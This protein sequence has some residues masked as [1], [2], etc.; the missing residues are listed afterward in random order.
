MHYNDIQVAEFQTQ[1]DL[2]SIEHRYDNVNPSYGQSQFK[3][4]DTG[5]Q[6][7]NDQDLSE[8]FNLVS[9]I[10]LIGINMFQ[11]VFERYNQYCMDNYRT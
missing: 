1:Q 7:Y 5:Q 8:L 3:C 11:T 10:K 2:S 9:E 4:R 6:N